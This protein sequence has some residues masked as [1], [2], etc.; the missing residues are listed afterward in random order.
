MAILNCSPTSISNE[1][2][3][4]L[5]AMAAAASHG[6]EETSVDGGVWTV[7]AYAQGGIHNHEVRTLCTWVQHH[8]RF[9]PMAGVESLSLD[10]CSQS[11]GELNSRC[12]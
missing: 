9:L 6:G 2:S 5:C 8:S 1:T 12:N 4:L 3:S 10:L 7:P 11:C